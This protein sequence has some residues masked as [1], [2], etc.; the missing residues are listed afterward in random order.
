MAGSRR[1]WR[2]G[3]NRPARPGIPRRVVSQRG[4][5][6][7]AVALPDDRRCHATGAGG[8]GHDGAGPGLADPKSS[9]DNIRLSTPRPR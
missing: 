2:A 5:V 7:V 3:G 1:R 4:L 8:W 6:L 9:S